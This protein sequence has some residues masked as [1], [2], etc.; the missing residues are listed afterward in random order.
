MGLGPMRMDRG[1]AASFIPACVTG[2]TPAAME[3]LDGHR[4]VP[5][6]HFAMNKSV[7]NAVEVAFDLH[8]VIDMN[9]RLFPLSEDVSCGGQR[10]QCG[11]VQLFETC[12]AA[13]FEFSK[14]PVIELLQ[15]FGDGLVESGQ[16]EESPFAQRR[17]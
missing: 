16:A 17:Q 4:G 13:A 5:A 12:R 15:Q 14:W 8:V 6:I 2:D 7:R 9:A 11:L 10:S 1:I 3:D